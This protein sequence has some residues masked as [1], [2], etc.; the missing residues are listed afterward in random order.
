MKGDPRRDAR[1]LFRKGMS[2][3]EAVSLLEPARTCGTPHLYSWCVKYVIA[4]T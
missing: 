4:K 1:G 2:F 3:G